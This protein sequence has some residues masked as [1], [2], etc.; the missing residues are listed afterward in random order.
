MKIVLATGIYPPVIGG[1]ATYTKAL[2]E[3]LA[4]S[5]H[6][7]TVVTYGEVEKSDKWTVESVSRS[8]PIIRWWWYSQ[9]LREVAADADIVYA[10]SSVSC[11]IPLVFVGLKKPKKVLRLGGD[12]LWERYTDFGGKK[13]LRMFYESPYVAGK[14]MMTR[15]LNRFDHIVFSTE[16]QQKIYEKHYRTLPKHSVLEN[17]LSVEIDLR[18]KESQSP[19]NPFRLLFMGRTVQF[20]NIPSLI[21][22]VAQVPDCFLTIAGEGPQDDM[23][24]KKVEHL[25]LHTRVQFSVSVSGTEKRDMFA[26]HDLLVLPSY[27]D[28]SPNTALEA[29][30]AGLPVLLTKETG[31]S[32][33]LLNGMT[34]AELQRPGDIVSAIKNAREGYAAMCS[35]VKG[36]L[37]ERSWTAVSEQHEALFVSL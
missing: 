4:N 13:S 11:G 10:F 20:K 1:P 7:I 12:F 17:A 37:E 5:G 22:A 30:A 19:H 26:S 28:I 33:T 6:E 32:S 34:L 27:T 16:F 23:L 25:G 24:R 9:K 8:I 2:A 36:A 15:L 21:D 3:K 29:R 18:K 31:L 14:W 35:S